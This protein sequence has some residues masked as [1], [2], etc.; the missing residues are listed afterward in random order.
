[1]KQLPQ[2]EMQ[3]E[4]LTGVQIS[5]QDTSMYTYFHL[6]V[7]VIYIRNNTNKR[8]HSNLNKTW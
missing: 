4:F 5:H 1:M 7:Y 6:H 2:Y 8:K 3:Y